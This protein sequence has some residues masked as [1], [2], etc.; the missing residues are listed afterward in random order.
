MHG[1]KKYD[2]KIMVVAALFGRRLSLSAGFNY[3][4]TVMHYV[5]GFSKFF[6]FD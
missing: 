5:F 4:D 6:G 3:F 1:K 2:K